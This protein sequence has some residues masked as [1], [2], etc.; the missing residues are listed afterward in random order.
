MTTAVVTAVAS[1]GTPWTWDTV[2]GSWDADTS[3]WE[4]QGITFTYTLAVGE[5]IG[6]LGF[7]GFPKTLNLTDSF[8]F[9]DVVT[10][11]I[12]LHLAAAF[13]T[14][15][16]FARAVGFHVPLSE[17]LSIAEAVSKGVGINKSEAWAT[18]VQWLRKA[19]GVL[20][21]LKI[22]KAEIQDA[23]FANLLRF[24]SMVGYADFRPF[25]PG[26]YKFQKGALRYVLQS[27]TADR[28][29]LNSCSITVDVPDIHDSGTFTCS[30]T[31]YTT[32]NFN[33]TFTAPPEVVTQLKGGTTIG[34]PRINNVTKFGFDVRIDITTTTFAA[35]T[36]SWSALGR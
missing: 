20:N 34:T 26:D 2:P 31:G 33:R 29:R 19:H 14:A 8:H 27:A 35:D 5:P 24:G 16:V 3:D 13:A 11:K 22:T 10:R 4:H 21:D 23:D 30:T 32:C 12:G 25:M 9:S 17:T 28:P 15:E 18:L 6:I 7:A 36:I 1:G